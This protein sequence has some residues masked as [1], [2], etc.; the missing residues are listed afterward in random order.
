MKM[1]TEI[2]PLTPAGCVRRPRSALLL[3]L[4]GAGLLSG[5]SPACAQRPRWLPLTGGL[6]ETAFVAVAADP[7]RPG[8]LFAGSP[9]AV[10][11]SPDG[12]A[13]WQERFR[14][15]AQAEVTFLA[16][17]PFDSRHVLVATTR[18]LYGSVDGG[19]RW[20]RVWRGA[21]TGESHGLVVRFHPTRRDEVFL[22]TMGGVFLS[23]DGGRAWQ[24][25]TSV[26]NNDAVR[27]LAVDPAAADRLYVL[28][29]RGLFAGSPA[30]GSWERLFDVTSAGEP[31]EE[32]E[33][34]PEDSEPEADQSRR[35]TAIAVDPQA[36]EVLYLATSEGL[37]ASHDRGISW[38]RTPVAGLGAVEIRHLILQAHSP[39]TAY[40]ATPHG[41]ARYATQEERWEILYAG[42][43]TQTANFLAATATKI[44]AA[45]NQGLYLL[46]L[47]EEQLLQGNWP[48]PQELLANF[49]HE[50]TIAQVREEA[51][52][53][54]EVHPDKITQ[55]RRQA[56]IKAF[57]PTVSL[58]Y[59]R[60]QDTYI[61][62]IGSTTNPTFDRLIQTED[63]S[64]GLGLSVDWDLGELI[65]NDD[66]TSIDVRS[67]LMVQL[68]D[69]IV[70]EVTRTYFER[71]RLQV[72]LLTEPPADPRTRLDRELRLQEL[73][74][75]LDG[76]T[77]GWF[78]TQLEVTGGAS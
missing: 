31:P 35:L 62:S 56:A 70:D 67:K 47:T 63:P 14:V 2:S 58:D 12:G 30:E 21:G 37:F 9:R 6:T 7:V 65:W 42:L 5:A 18:G 48:A 34:L 78:S 43:P 76:L 61:S 29:D 8:Q 24:E 50:P 46:D 11:H 16:I 74:A 4:V 1:T 3:G 51:I 59:D 10:F 25:T 23:T 71:R 54:A 22:G 73:T 28:T 20:R 64:H 45:T 32:S 66:Q 55:W 72:E 26:F 68:R 27:D 15:P 77:G 41:I 36:F 38:Q 19:F 60:D 17:D 33:T 53:Y 49:V 57:L 75:M 40:A 44:Y 69:D 39:T 52:R 13:H